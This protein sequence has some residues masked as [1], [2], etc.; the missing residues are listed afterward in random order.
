[1]LYRNKFFAILLI[2][3]SLLVLK[4]NAAIDIAC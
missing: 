1:M 3:C 2:V 4:K